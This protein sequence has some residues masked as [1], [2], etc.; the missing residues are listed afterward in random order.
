M[1]SKKVE[2]V[3]VD[4]LA[5]T[6][7]AGVKA[8]RRRRD[9]SAGPS[10]PSDG[11]QGPKRRQGRKPGRGSPVTVNAVDNEYLAL[12]LRKRAASYRR[13]G[14]QL[15]I[16]EEGARQC[17]LRALRRLR[18]TV[19]ES[20]V[21]VLA[22]ELQ[23]LDDVTMPVLEKA[24]KGDLNAVDRLLRIQD[25]RAKYLGLD[26]AIRAELSGPGGGPVQIDLTGLSD[27]QLAAVHELMKAGGAAV[28]E[29]TA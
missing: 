25:R 12:E 4:A 20:A 23:R 1:A 13:I 11:V 3:E 27:E 16:T 8:P 26:A 7:L 10:K 21:E 6:G 19:D 22:L 24:A 9:Q 29:A 2:A 28:P 18:E 14:Q 17:V 15:G 5:A